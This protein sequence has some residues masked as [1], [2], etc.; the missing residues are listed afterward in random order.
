MKIRKSDKAHIQVGEFECVIDKY[1]CLVNPPLIDVWSKKNV[2][3]YI[4]FLEKL[5]P[6]L[7]D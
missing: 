7:E 5:L 6:Y 1:G 3:D 4:Q 2:Q